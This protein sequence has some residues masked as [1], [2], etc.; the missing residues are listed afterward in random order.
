[1]WQGRKEL[2]GAWRGAWG[3][4]AAIKGLGGLNHPIQSLCLAFLVSSVGVGLLL[5]SRA[6][7]RFLEQEML[8]PSFSLACC[9]SELMASLLLSLSLCFP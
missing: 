5:L 7:S 6:T 2:K 9:N 8:S 4:G 3:L 1:M